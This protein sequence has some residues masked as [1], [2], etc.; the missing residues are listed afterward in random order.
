MPTETH[1]KIEDLTDIFME[2]VKKAAK[3]LNES[4][5]RRVPKKVILDNVE[6]ENNY[7]CGIKMVNNE[8]RISKKLP[9]DKIEAILQREALITFLPEVDFPHIYDLAWAYANADVSWWRECSQPIKL[10]TFPTYE[11][12]DMFSLYSQKERRSIIKSTVKSILLLY[13]QGQEITLKDYLSLLIISRR[14]PSIKISKKEEKVLKSLVGAA[15]EAK[16][17]NLAEISGLSLASVSRAIRGLLAKKVIHG[18][19]NLNPL[20]LSLSI[21]FME[22]EDPS[23]EEI[24]FL[25]SFPYTYSVYKPVNSDTYYFA[26]LMPMKYKAA[27]LKLRGRGLRIGRAV[28]FSFE[29]HSLEPINPEEVLSMMIDE[30]KTKPEVLPY[31]REEKPPFK[32]DKK[33]IIALNQLLQKGKVSRSQ[34]R[35]MG[36]TNP[37]ERFSRY[38]KGGIIFKG[39]LPTGLGIGEAVIAKIDVPYRDFLRVRRALGS[40]SSPVLY[41]VEGSLNGVIAVCF[42]NQE[43]LSTFIKS[44]KII[45]GESLELLDILVS[46][47]P[48][49]WSLPVDLWNEEEQTFEMDLESFVRAFP[50]R[51]SESEWKNII[52][53]YT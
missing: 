40:V 39:Y 23:K 20:R 18:P 11:A 48:S 14:Y 31:Y 38:R 19:Y 53:T 22:L 27:L 25:E 36:V 37:A 15:S 13:E 45:F 28:R 42:V 21:F 7:R 24:D 43:I 32:L 30:Y 35:K 17:E 9:R 12:P 2:E 3:F 6:I 26:F 10:P 52:A 41:F 50:D 51:I 44:M 1:E 5:V 8:L 46:A 47:G 29:M 4:P 49:S 34:L 33:D 16:L